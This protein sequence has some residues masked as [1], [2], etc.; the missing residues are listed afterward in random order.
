MCKQIIVV[1]ILV[2]GV[3]SAQ[4][5]AY[6]DLY[7]ERNALSARSLAMG[8]TG[9]A[10]QQDNY[11]A[12]FINPAAISTRSNV[13]LKSESSFADVH[14]FTLQGTLALD[15]TSEITVNPVDAAVPTGTYETVFGTANEII[16]SETAVTVSNIPLLPNQQRRLSLAYS[17]ISVTDIPIAELSGTELQVADMAG[18][19]EQEFLLGYAQ[20]ITDEVQAGV[21]V[22]YLKDSLNIDQSIYDQGN[23]AG[24]DVDLGVLWQNANGDIGFGYKNV[25]SALSTDGVINLDTGVKSSFDHGLYA[26]IHKKYSQNFEI[27]ADIL[28]SRLYTLVYGLGLEYTCMPELRLRCGY[29]SLQKASVGLGL[30]LNNQMVIDYTYVPD[31]GTVMDNKHFFSLSWLF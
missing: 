8:M 4:P 5:A 20:N 3:L 12:V 1:G 30:V 23:A 22:K 7:L 25:L 26:G 28:N 24:G 21:T 29:N 15:K 6:R 13:L 2:I 27:A 16:I 18:Y 17:N 14:R 19:S 9:A 11:D 10:L 31:F